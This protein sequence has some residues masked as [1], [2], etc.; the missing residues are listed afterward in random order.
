MLQIHPG[1]D[2]EGRARAQ[3]AL[4][5]EAQILASCAHPNIIPVLG[6]VQAPGEDGP[7]GLAMLQA[8]GGSLLARLECAPQLCPRCRRLVSE[9]A[10]PPK[11]ITLF[12]LA[13]ASR[14]C[15][16]TYESIPHSI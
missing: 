6:M 13:G 11:D 1:L 12:G 7:S 3:A 4:T 10:D 2:P 8:P 14:P 9:L 16:C 15:S 5:W